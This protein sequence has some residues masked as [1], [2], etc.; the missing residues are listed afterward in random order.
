MKLLIR[1]STPTEL[2]CYEGMA[3]ALTMA[4][5]DHSVQLYLQTPVYGLLLQ[6]NSRLQGMIKSLSLYDVAP[7]WI[8]DTPSSQW[9]MSMVADDIKPQL[10]FT[11]KTI[12]IQDFDQVLSF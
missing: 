9:L 3:L 2:S 1:L 11:P 6:E 5:F 10:N 12:S 8:D 4:T 7:A